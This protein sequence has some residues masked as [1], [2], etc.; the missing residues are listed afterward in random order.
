MFCFETEKIESVWA[1][2]QQHSC[3][4]HISFLDGFTLFKN[5]LQSFIS[6]K[7]EERE[8]WKTTSKLNFSSYVVHTYIVLRSV[9]NGKALER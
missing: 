9:K 7:Y 4:T 8:E 1:S 3:Y 6:W 2:C 5:F